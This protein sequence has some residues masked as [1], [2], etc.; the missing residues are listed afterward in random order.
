MILFLGS[1]TDVHHHLRGRLANLDIDTSQ[2]SRVVVPSRALGWALNQTISTMPPLTVL[3]EWL[4]QILPQH[5]MAAPTGTWEFLSGL[6]PESLISRSDRQTPGFSLSAAHTV[7]SGRLAGI[8]ST[9][10]RAS[11][12][13]AW[14]DLFAWY[15][16][17]FSGVLADELRLYDY[18]AAAE[19]VPGHP[20]GMLFCYGFGA[21]LKPLLTLIGR[22]DRQVPVEVWMI[23][24]LDHAATAELEAGAAEVVHLTGLSAASSERIRVAVPEGLDPF[25]AAWLTL[26]GSR[27]A[28]PEGLVL[29]E[30]EQATRPSWRRMLSRA[31]GSPVTGSIKSRE[32]AL[33]QIFTRIMAGQ[34]P[35]D[36]QALWRAQVG[37]SVSG[38][39][40]A[41]WVGRTRALTSW[42][43]LVALI[44]EAADV[45][46]TAWAAVQDWARR[47]SY[48][49]T[50][51][52]PD[53]D[54]IVR[55]LTGVEV[56]PVVPDQVPIL[57]LAEAIWVPGARL[58]V[59]GQPWR[60]RLPNPFRQ[61]PSIREWWGRTDDFLLDQ[62]A[63]QAWLA[64]PDARCWLIDSDLPQLA[65][66]SQ[67]VVGA[68][69][70]PMSSERLP[71]VRSHQWY[72]AWRDGE[73]HSSYTGRVG[74]SGVSGLLPTR[75]SPSAIEDFGRCPLSFLLGRV[76]RI[77][78]LPRTGEITA[79]DTGQWAHRALELI[80]RDKK[81]LSRANVREAV[82]QSVSEQVEAGTVP[83]L[84]LAY[85]KER[86]TSELYEALLRDEWTPAG[87]SEVEVDIVWEWIWPMR[88]RVDR[89]DH[90]DGGTLRLIDYKTG[91]IPNPFRVTPAN[92][93]LVLYQKAVYEQLSQPVQAEY[94]GVS[95]RSEFRRRIVRPAQAE[96]LH[97]V[98][99]AIGQGVAERLRR[100][101]FLPVPDPRLKPCRV[102]SFQ[103]V[104]PEQVVE[105]AQTK[106][107][108]AAD[109]TVLWNDTPEESR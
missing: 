61:D 39:W 56:D 20:G 67:V 54:W 89:L 59:V 74:G 98:V 108:S 57:P 44:R 17:Q 48:L 28:P 86:L 15:N 42:P 97:P 101:D 52:P 26:W 79:A 22:W 31:T 62:R 84:Y 29:V 66:W 41:D 99:E 91:E 76:L 27:G 73:V 5:I 53:P 49:E 24:S 103:L 16:R 77:S 3:P 96:S 83:A 38:P 47:A 14:P 6:V 60:P 70:W 13:L 46:Q 88:G 45:H 107:A 71:R 100:E 65:G 69:P 55:A 34:A 43:D 75:L 109:Y 10:A 80:V 37:P 58:A 35:S 90:L 95:Q 94:L 82:V 87:H 19:K 9:E 30:S 93:Q 81:A 72:Q 8:R 21:A 106:N 104:C 33:W 85:Q 12:R 51:A 4:S 40:L 25:D 78:E 18:A 64:D 2:A 68:P 36:L 63:W 7:R 105:Y 102:C 50:V 23:D 1:P 32:A 11:Q 92:L